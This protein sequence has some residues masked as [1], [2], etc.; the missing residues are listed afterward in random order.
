VG[1]ACNCYTLL[2][3]EDNVG[4]TVNS[5]ARRCVAAATTKSPLVNDTGTDHTLKRMLAL[6]VTDPHIRI[7]DNP[8]N[9]GFGGAYRP[10]RQHEATS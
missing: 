6:V 5:V 7:L 9:L 2:N 10:K 8:V 1:G 3:E 4:P